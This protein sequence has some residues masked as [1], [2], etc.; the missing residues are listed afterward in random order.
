MHELGLC[1][2]LVARAEALARERGGGRILAL[3]V[4]AGAGTGAGMGVGTDL[5]HLAETL[6]L[7]CRGGPAEGAALELEPPRLR[8][9]A[10]GAEGQALGGQAPRERS[11]RARTPEARTPEVSIA[12]AGPARCPRCGSPELLP[13]DGP[14]LV[15]LELE[16]EAPDGG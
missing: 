8:C 2:A 11:P 15:L 5:G 16:V 6:R 1:R 4:R 13:L 9:L 14:G 10:C 7:A 3:R 12:V